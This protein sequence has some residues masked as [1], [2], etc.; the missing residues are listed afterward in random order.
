VG[1]DHA[2]IVMSKKRQFEG[3]I[4]SVARELVAIEHQPNSSFVRTP[5]LYPSGALVVV[6][7]EPGDG[8]FIV[9]DW[10]F[11][12]QEAD[13]MGASTL[14]PRHARVIAEHA[15]VRFDNQAFFI[16]EASREQLPGAIVTV[17]NCSQ[18][19]AIRAA[20][21]L[22]EKTFEDSKE[23][24]YERLISVFDRKYVAKNAKVIGSSTTEW[25]VAALVEDASSQ[26]ATIFEPVSK[27]HS[28]I[29][30]AT[31]KFHD[32]ALLENAPSRVAI[33]RK[34]NEFGTF[35]T[36][37]SQAAKVIDEDVP[38]ETII[39]LSRAA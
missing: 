2:V 5:L 1:T 15:G 27:H 34:R 3:V 33:V 28:S 20:D 10:G 23:R 6:R 14:Y 39:R 24:L 18:E 31:M 7:I 21:A 29:A 35:L 32:I 36:V 26:R 37:L 22:A 19:A 4:E 30:H 25:H 17:A 13:L 16:L 11:G 12:F 9:S 8:K 38:D